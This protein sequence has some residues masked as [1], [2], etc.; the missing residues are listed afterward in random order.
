MSVPQN[1]EHVT[2]YGATSTDGNID[3]VTESASLSTDGSSE[4]VTKSQL[5]LQ[6]LP[7]IL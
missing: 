5:R 1:T 2:E 7:H 4:S 6:I 3:D